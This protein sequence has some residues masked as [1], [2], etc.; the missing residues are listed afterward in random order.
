MPVADGQRKRIRGIVRT[1]QLGEMENAF[2]HFHHL[3]FLRAAVADNGQLHLI[4]CI[5][6]RM[7]SLLC[8]RQ[9]NYTARLRN[10]NAG[11]DVFRPLMYK[12]LPRRRISS[13]GAIVSS[14]TLFTG[15]SY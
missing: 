4:R 7:Q 6:Y 10:L 2:R 15:R 13:N 1:R 5:G 12:N 8:Q 11:C 3:F 9:Q 14:F